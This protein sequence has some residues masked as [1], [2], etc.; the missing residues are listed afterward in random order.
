MI[1]DLIKDLEH[2]SRNAHL[3]HLR[4]NAKHDIDVWRRRKVNIEIAFNVISTTLE[5]KSIK[6]L[7][8]NMINLLKTDEMFEIDRGY[9]EDECTAVLFRCIDEYLVNKFG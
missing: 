7:Y 6:S 9:Y 2:V 8:N 5:Y 4:D 1:D 3:K